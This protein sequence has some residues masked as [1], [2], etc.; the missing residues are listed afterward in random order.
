[1]AGPILMK[2]FMVFNLGDFRQ[3]RLFQNQMHYFFLHLLFSPLLGLPSRHL[4]LFKFSLYVSICY[5]NW[6]ELKNQ[7]EKNGILFYRRGDR[8]GWEGS[9]SGPISNQN[10]GKIKEFG[11]TFIAWVLSWNLYSLNVLKESIWSLFTAAQK[12][13][14]AKVK[15]P[16]GLQTTFKTLRI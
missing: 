2:C 13:P 9:W 10:F 3:L 1:M 12:S 8:V 5:L 4:L 15:I 7:I 6:I 14:L 16:N 11:K